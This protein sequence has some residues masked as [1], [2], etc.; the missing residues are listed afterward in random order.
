MNQPQTVRVED[1]AP[2]APAAIDSSLGLLVER[3][4][5]VEL[6]GRALVA[7]G[8]GAGS[9][10]VLQGPSGI[11][12]SRL[13]EAC[14]PLASEHGVEVLAAT[15]RELERPLEFGVA[16]QLF[17]ARVAAADAAEREALLAGPARL[18]G[19]LLDDGPDAR[20]GEGQ[21]ESLVHGLH[22]ICTNLARRTPLAIL[23]DDAHLADDRS[24]ALVLY[25][26][27]RV[28]ELPLVLVI[29]IGGAPRR[30]PRALLQIADDP[31]VTRVPIEPLTEDGVAEWLRGT[32]F[33]RADG[34]FCSACHEATGG[35]PFLLR[36]LALALADDGIEPTRK[37]ARRIPEAG[38][39]AIARELVLR[40]GGLGPG[41]VELARA[42]AVVGGQAE[43]RHCAALA[44]VEL[45]VARRLADEMVDLELFAQAPRL[46]FVHPVARRALYADLPPGERADAHLR[47]A[48]I[49]SEEGAPDELVADHL[50]M[51]APAATPWVVDALSAGARSAIGRGEP[52]KAVSYLRR[53]LEEPPS[54]E[55]R[56]QVM[57]Q[58]GGAEI[59][60]GKDEAVERLSAAV[61]LVEDPRQ[62]GVTSLC[63]GR[64]LFAQGRHRDAV[65][66]FV[67]GSAAVGNLDLDLR[68]QLEMARTLVDRAGGLST[69]GVA[70][71]ANEPLSEVIA[72]A[73]T[74]AGRVLLASMAFE[75]A[76]AGTPRDVV[77]ELATG[78]LKNGALVEEETSD[79]L[80]VYVAASALV[81]AGD[82]E[83]AERVIAAT[84]GDA[85]AR[86]SV[87][88]LA[89]ACYTRGWIALQRGRVDDAAADGERAVSARQHGWRVWLPGAHAVFASALTARGDLGAARRQLELGDKEGEANPE[90]P[91]PVLLVTRACFE[92]ENGEPQAALDAFRECGARL[93]AAGVINPACGPW[94]SGA[95]LSLAA[96]G[97]RAEAEHLLEEELSLATDFG[98]PGPIGWALYSQG[99]LR[100][101]EGIEL[102][103]EAARLLGEAGRPLD[104]ARALAAMGLVL[105]RAGKR[106][107]A[108]EPLRE[109]LD[110]AERCHA[111]ALADQ[112]RTETAATGARPRRTALYGMEALTPRELQ[113]ARLA[114]QGKSN[115]EI[116]HALFVT[117]K[118][119]EWHLRHAYDKL[120][121]GSKEE[122]QAELAGDL[123]AG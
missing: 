84:V 72:A 47:L 22:G 28:H 121:V 32:V 42:A 64:A 45:A 96:L 21:A 58:L 68:R 74:P 92:L 119:V 69:A 59:V 80:G 36:E 103:R 117:I 26:L 86:G 34:A 78:A 81:F 107:D 31:A 75:G 106:R 85:R 7:A 12:K 62:R 112:A 33:S 116:A 6:L 20:M 29:G 49:L 120:G 23:I 71:T 4:A 57:L 53:A 13:M 18:A 44:G 73:D 100:N 24:L 66:A 102:M 35:N 5:E 41:A 37:G 2:P 56:A 27:Q 46:T 79:G 19:P 108:R 110:I 63:I 48:R 43:L 17:A 60:A 9:A 25:L 91:L 52:D 76:L 77:L 94:R 99:R 61:A 109:A 15:G 122:L 55:A 54:R 87:L 113:V 39:P 51:A 123:A 90:T 89:T 1:P 70:Q 118:T 95:A 88:G 114:A 50:L 82:L 3:G 11:G 105:R 111:W 67:Q 97:D 40:L 10:F 8:S 38:P 98:A 93:E 65:E 30:H 16:L 115:R 14:L 83:A 104:R 101:G